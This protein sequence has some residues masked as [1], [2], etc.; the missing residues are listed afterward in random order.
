MYEIFELEQITL[1]FKNRIPRN[2]SRE[3]M[4][5]PLFKYL[6]IALSIT[7]FTQVNSQ[8]CGFG[9]LGLSGIYGGYS[10]QQ[11]KADGLNEQLNW[12]MNPPWSSIAFSDE[13]NFNEAR[14]FKVGINL[15]R[16]E[17]SNF[18]FT[19]K[20]YYQFLIEEQNI[21]YNDYNHYD[22][23]LEMNNWGIGFDFGIPLFSFINWKIAEGELKFFSPKLST[24]I[25]NSN[26][27]ANS[28]KIENVFT[29]DKVKM[30]FSLGSGLI[31]IIVKD[32][33]SLEATG[34]YTFVEID[35]L[36]SDLDGSSIPIEGSD[37]KFISEGGI[38]AFIQLN[39]GIPF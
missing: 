3:N 36:T 34:M 32:Y 16:A 23:K 17:Y 26:P 9:C 18:F 19:F 6:I 39:V 24:S 30:G 2:D 27:L 11:Y 13:Y 31:F 29:P 7:A 33:I 5:Q 37:T 10:L 8:T 20:G 12:N 1:S 22:A 21:T 28:V 15:V 38:Q 4:K 35:N 25:Y 14:G